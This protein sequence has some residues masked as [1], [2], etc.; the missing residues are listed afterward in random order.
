[1]QAH[2]RLVLVVGDSLQARSLVQLVLGRLSYR[3]A[4]A[5][6]AAAA[7]EILARE[8]VDLVLAAVRLRDMPGGAFAR[9]VRTGHGVP[10]LLFGDPGELARA[11]EEDPAL[12]P[13]DCFPRP[14]ALD[15]LIARIRALLAARPPAGAEVEEDLRTIRLRLREVAGEEEA[16]RELAGLFL[17]T[18]AGYLDALG[19]EDRGRFREVAHALKGAARNVGAARLAELAE[20]LEHGGP[21][22]AV[23]ERARRHLRGLAGALA[24]RAGTLS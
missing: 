4:C 13:A 23:L 1:M 14:V 24:E 6:D 19:R 15:R 17:R 2:P 22:A 21:D 11:R 8:P 3:V 16:A 7:L 10:V 12:A 20:R 9:R 18:A 5:D